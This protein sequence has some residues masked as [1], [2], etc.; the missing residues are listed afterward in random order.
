[1]G[2]V[3]FM[4]FMSLVSGPVVLLG[5]NVHPSAQISGA[6]IWNAIRKKRLWGA[7]DFGPCLTIITKLKK[8]I[9]LYVSMHKRIKIEL[10]KG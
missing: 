5:L 1:M 6:D 2:F 4:K 8:Y 7:F 10:S 9:H 3:P